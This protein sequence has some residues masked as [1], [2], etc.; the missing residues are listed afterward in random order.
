MNNAFIQE[1]TMPKDFGTR[2]KYARECRGLLQKELAE[3]SGVSVT[4]LGGWESGK[5]TPTLFMATAVA[6]VLKVSLDWL[7]GRVD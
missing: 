3:K 5:F 1:L 6:D 2:L 7:A 4:S